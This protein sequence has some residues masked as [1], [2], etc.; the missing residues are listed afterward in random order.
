LAQANRDTSTTSNPSPSLSSPAFATGL[1][2]RRA[3]EEWF[4]SLGGD[5]KRG[6]EY[7]AG[8]RSLPNPGSCYLADGTSAGEWTQG[9][10]AAQRR[11]APTDVRRNAEPDYRQ[12]WNAYSVPAAP[13]SVAAATPPA[14]ESSRA[15]AEGLADRQA[16]ENYFS[17]LSGQGKEGAEY[18]ASH[19]SVSGASCQPVTA[20]QEGQWQ[21]GCLSAKR[22][23]DPTDKRRLGEPDYRQG[24]NSYTESV[25]QPTVL[26]PVASVPVPIANRSVD[27]A[28]QAGPDEGASPVS[29]NPV[30]AI[31]T[32]TP[33]LMGGTAPAKEPAQMVAADGPFAVGKFSC[34]NALDQIDNLEINTGKVRINDFTI[35]EENALFAKSAVVLNLSASGANRSEKSI[36]LSVEAVGYDE[37]DSLTFA[38]TA[39]PSFG[40]VS[41]GKTEQIG[42]N[43]YVSPGT[44]KNTSKVCLRVNGEF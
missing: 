44:L 41:A 36:H 13:A 6:V 29:S 26:A 10:L 20:E 16:W 43:I 39:Q 7:W 22:Q 5:F 32:P 15:Y 28:L 3:Y 38:V 24:W 35:A 1:A 11:L 19:R 18:W 12:G 8:Q 2:D 30:Y 27:N 40:S 42:G 17:S 31:S 14:A 21:T 23:L 9:C 33:K 34:G 25:S 37:T 4:A